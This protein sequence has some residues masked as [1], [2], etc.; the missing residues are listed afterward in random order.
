MSSV[1]RVGTVVLLGALSLY[2]TAGRGVSPGDES[3]FLLVAKRVADGDDLYRDV[4]YSPLP[5]AVYVTAAP[6]ALLGA[7]I[8][9]VEVLI[10]LTWS[11]TALV[12]VGYA[13]RVTGSRAAAGLTLMA[14][15]VAAPPQR[16]SLYTPLAVLLLLVCMLIA[17]RLVEAGGGR[18]AL[19]AGAVAG[20]SFASK[21]TIGAGAFAALLLCLAFAPRAH[22][23]R[24]VLASLGGFA[25]V[26][27]VLAIVLALSGLLDDAVR[28]GFTDKGEYLAYGSLSYWQALWTAA[29]FLPSEPVGAFDT[30][31]LLLA[32][33]V[34]AVLV[35][36]ARSRA[37]SVPVLV[38]AAFAIAALA[39]TYP[40]MSATHIGWVN[41]AVIVCAVAAVGPS[42][43]VRRRIALAAAPLAIGCAI[44]AALIPVSWAGGQLVV[45]SLP[46]FEG[47]PLSRTS[48]REPARLLHSV[49]RGE[50]VLF[51]TDH[52]GFLY[53]VTGARNPT[54]YDVPAASNIG[55]IELASIAAD[56]RSGAI[57]QACL[58][59]RLAYPDEPSLQ[60]LA[61]ER[62]LRR[63]LRP[64]ADLGP[65]VLY[66]RA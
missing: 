1:R 59:G 36:A 22:R 18:S 47:M 17:K 21:Q 3:W 25:A 6:V 19:L 52:A 54:P 32:P 62:V 48:E 60:P 37:L 51:V 39:A 8:A 56:V 34:A 27:A 49:Q 4:F 57:S 66:S 53:L 12:A 40:R 13:L 35:V 63:T 33:A 24:A 58:G 65:C 44:A 38:P 29:Q 5:L 10:A 15:V 41:P 42:I 7:H 9:I 43:R 16:N 26:S 30:L 64:V 20:L 45:S 55:Q 11:C 46:A 23:T 14:L 28:T 2:L 31:P 61:L 50:S